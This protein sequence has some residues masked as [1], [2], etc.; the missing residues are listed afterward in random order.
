MS[1]FRGKSIEL[2]SGGW[3][4]GPHLSGHYLCN[5]GQATNLSGLSFCCEGDASWRHT[6]GVDAYISVC[7]CSVTSVVSNS[8]RPYGLTVAHQ[9]PLSMGFSRQEYW[10][11]LPYLPPGDLLD[12][13][14]PYMASRFLPLSHQGSPSSLPKR[15]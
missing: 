4:W 6:S 3:T 5:Q 14:I 12:P 10:S 9:A 8:L 15:R 7:V 11:G 13:R 1:W 2:E